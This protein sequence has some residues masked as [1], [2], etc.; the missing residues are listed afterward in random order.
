MPSSSTVAA[1]GDILATQYNN[2][3]KDVIEG[4]LIYGADAGG[5]DTYAITIDAQY[6]AYVTGTLLVV[7]F[8]TA[9]TGACTLAANGLANIDIR[10][11]GALALETGD[12]LAGSTHLLIKEASVFT[13]LSNLGTGLT[14]AEIV[15]LNG[16]S[17]NVTSTNLNTLT[18]GSSSDAD[19][20]H[21]HATNYLKS[22][23]FEEVTSTG[24]TA[25]V[26][27]GFRPRV[28]HA[29]STSGRSVGHAYI[30]EDGGTI[31]QGYT[32]TYDVTAE[33]SNAAIGKDSANG[34][35]IT[36]SNVT[37]SAFQLNKTGTTNR[38]DM[39]LIVL[40]H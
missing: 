1:G 4:Q 18:A 17:A 31:N 40:G 35:T 21:T 36:V 10:K 9:N 30:S 13:I 2:L 20:L 7:K 39:H 33:G 27:V 14:T 26:T 5:T 38:Y 8:N 34:S 25:T 12:I 22:I 3:R 32:K 11:R 23:Y 16:I 15:Q 19:A 24:A 29:I 6:T 37:S 28:I